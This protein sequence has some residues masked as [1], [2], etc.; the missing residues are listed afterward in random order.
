[1]LAAVTGFFTALPQLLKMV[2]GFM[3]WLNQVSGNDPMGHLLKISDTF[4]RLSEAK[5]EEDYAQSA[6]D[7]AG[8]IRGLPR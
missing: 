6:K 5:T 7:I 8:I 2:Q 4:K 3:G 1:M